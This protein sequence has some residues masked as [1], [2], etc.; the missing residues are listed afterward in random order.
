MGG[1]GR[2]G[3][4][5]RAQGRRRRGRGDGGCEVS[6]ARVRPV[7]ARLGLRVRHQRV[8]AKRG[9]HR[10][11]ARQ[12]LTRGAGRGREQ[13]AGGEREPGDTAAVAP[14][15]PRARRAAPSRRLASGLTAGTISASGA[16]RVRRGEK[17]DC[18][19]S[20]KVIGTLTA[21]DSSSRPSNE[22]WAPSAT[23]AARRPPSDWPA[24][25]RGAAGG[26]C[27][28]TASANAAASATRSLRRSQLN[29]PRV[30]CGGDL[31]KSGIGSAGVP[32]S[33]PRRHPLRA[34]RG[35][36]GRTCGQRCPR[37]RGGGRLRRRRRTVSRGGRGPAPRSSAR[38]HP[39]RSA[40]RGRPGRV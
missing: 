25:R 7:P 9:H 29:R 20:A 11:V 21:A 31:G 10:L 24:S 39:P 18:T 8:V 2:E 37:R 23:K 35:Q 22:A 6:S 3:A 38:A 14:D 19:R 15:P 30:G 4:G 16:R 34:C 27:S 1:A 40:P 17:A 32:L 33:C 26:A 12:V 28:R 36:P 5:V 13:R